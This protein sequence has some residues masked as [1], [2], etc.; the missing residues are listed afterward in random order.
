MTDADWMRLALDAAREAGARGEVPVGAVLVKDGA[1]VATGRNSPIASNDPTAHAEVDALRAGAAALGNYRLEGCTLYVTLEPCAMCAGAAL[2]ARLDRIVFG[3]AEP[4]S[5]AAGSVI[6]LFAE[7]RLNHRTEIEGGVLAEECA[8]L[9]R[10]F[11]RGRREASRLA[12]QPLR[13][14]ALRTPA[15][16]FEGLLDYPFASHWSSGSTS[17]RGWRMHFL[18]EG[19][20]DAATVLCLHAPGQWSYFFRYLVV[21]A[22][23][24]WLAPDLIGFGMSDKP[25]REDVHALEWHADVLMEWIDT[26][27][28]GLLALAVAPGAGPLADLLLQRR[29][30]RFVGALPVPDAA[31]GT[32]SIAWRAPYPDRGHEAALRALGA[33]DPGS[34]GPSPAQSAQVARDAMGYF[35]P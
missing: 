15:K 22:G 24:R 33:S 34:S 6:D 23:P 9:L 11:F 16:R 14:D 2:H 21:H 25:K 17:Q 3:A 20:P 12:A 30:E 4:A 32:V 29:P 18:D 31:D 5:G 26:L 13:D 35:A 1:I 10:D 28:V 27:D 19:P 7:P 8:I